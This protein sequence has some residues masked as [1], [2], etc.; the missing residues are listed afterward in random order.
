MKT[1]DYTKKL[2]FIASNQRLSHRFVCTD[3]EGY[4]DK[5]N[6][7]MIEATKHLARYPGTSQVIKVGYDH[8]FDC[9]EEILYELKKVFDECT[10][11]ED[12]GFN[13]IDVIN[14]IENI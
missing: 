4:Y 8:D 6:S 5:Q 10:A 9:S 12:L 2:F 7:S 11:V 14:D 13:I 1:I 3:N